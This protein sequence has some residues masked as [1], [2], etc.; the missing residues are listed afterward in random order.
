MQILLNP[1]ILN[2]YIMKN[3]IL[4]LGNVYSTEAKYNEPLAC[5][6]LIARETYSYS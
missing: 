3:L 5:E 4:Q 6:K 1:N 2:P